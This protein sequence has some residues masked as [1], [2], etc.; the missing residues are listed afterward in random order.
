M[1]LPQLSYIYWLI[2]FKKESNH[3]PNLIKHLSAS[4]EKWLSNSSSDEN[5]FKEAALLRRYVNKAGYIN[6][7]FYHAPSANNQEI[8]KENRQRNVIWFNLPYCKSV[9]TRI[10][11]S[12]L[13]LTDAHS[14]KKHTFI[15]IFNR[16]KVKVSY[17][18]NMQN[19]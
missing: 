19:I 17:S 8:K 4:I 12:F 7:W 3:R 15:K 1:P 9:T 14:P 10:G 5:V 18:S 11:K 6:K 2:Y 16:N 13:Q